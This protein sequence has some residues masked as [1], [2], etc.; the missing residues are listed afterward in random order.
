M[1]YQKKEVANNNIDL[2]LFMGRREEK[3]VCYSA[4]YSSDMCLVL[5]ICTA[6]R[7]FYCIIV[8]ILHFNGHSKPDGCFL[9]ERYNSKK[10]TKSESN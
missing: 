9:M 1:K 10:Q 8:Y 7:V 3:D 6:R 2:V 4:S 5:L